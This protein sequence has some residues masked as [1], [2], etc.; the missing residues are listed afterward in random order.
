MIPY[1]PKST[2]R[3]ILLTVICFAATSCIYS[4]EDDIKVTPAPSEDLDFAKALSNSTQSR[5]VFKEF[6]TRYQVT[7]TYLSPE[8]RA[9]F[10]KRIE[11]VYKKSDL[12]LSEAAEKAGFFVSI[13]SPEDDRVDLT[14]PHHWTVGVEDPTNSKALF[15]PILIKRL[16]DK[17]RWRAYFESVTDWTVEYLVIFDI[18]STNVN[19]SK[20]LNKKNI[21]LTFANADAQVSLMW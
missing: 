9:A 21:V 12:N 10:A 19:T 7:A 1:L 16:N 15:K 8:F 5:T 17:E 14:N 18:P 4:V 3:Q 6:E 11:K 20:L 2:L 13:H